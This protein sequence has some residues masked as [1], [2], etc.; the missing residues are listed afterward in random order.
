[1]DDAGIENAE[2]ALGRLRRYVELLLQ[3]NRSVSNLISRNDEPRV[4]IGH[5]L[6]SIELAGWLK[7]RNLERWCD[8]GSGG[9]LPAIPLAI[10]GVG[11]SWDLVE[12]RRTKTLFLSRCTS[13]LGLTGIRVLRARLEDLIDNVDQPTGAATDPELEDA[14]LESG[15]LEEASAEHRDDLVLA[16]PY[17][18]LSSRATLT[19]SPTL[20]YAA[21]IVRPGGEAFLWKGSRMSEELRA[22]SSWRDAWDAGEV[23]NLSVEHAVVANFK[24]R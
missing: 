4:L 24:R 1:M 20:E 15:E 19:L 18:A 6:P 23:K 7:S 17:D 8:F 10:C 12:S 13:E 16:P 11:T 21:R 2:A 9:G 3:W 22:S 5:V 14:D